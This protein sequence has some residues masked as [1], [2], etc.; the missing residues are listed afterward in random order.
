VDGIYSVPAV[1]DNYEIMHVKYVTDSSSLT[2]KE[3]TNDHQIW[4]M[5][6]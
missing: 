2:K 4:Y 3:Y 1:C 5:W 6:D